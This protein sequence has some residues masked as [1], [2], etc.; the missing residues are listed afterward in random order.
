M[1]TNRQPPPRRD[2]ASHV[3]AFLRTAS[4]RYPVA[5]GKQVLEEDALEAFHR[6]GAAL[7]LRHENGALQRADDEPCELL[8]LGV[9]RQLTR[10]DR[11]FEAVAHGRLVF[12][13]HRCDTGANRV[14]LL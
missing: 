11:G 13:E 1:Y 14:A 7:R 5:P 9:G 10:V 6:Y 2:L 3:M 8:Y 4:F 12:R